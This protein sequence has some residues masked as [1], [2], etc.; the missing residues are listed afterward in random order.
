MKENN[1]LEQIAT[2]GN[3]SSTIQDQT[4]FGSNA[5]IGLTSTQMRIIEI[6]KTAKSDKYPLAD[7]YL[8]AIYA[9]KN[10]YNPDRFSQAAQSLRELLEKLPRVFVKN[11]IP[12]K[13]KT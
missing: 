7:W 5:P 3:V 4:I 13:N 12:S 10:T 6:L 8:G 11:E 2:S 9:V 1:E